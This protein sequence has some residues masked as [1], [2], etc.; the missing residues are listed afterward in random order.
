MS[1]LCAIT[2]VDK[3]INFKDTDVGISTRGN[4]LISTLQDRYFSI[5]REKVKSDLV[6]RQTESRDAAR[7]GNENLAE[8]QQ[9]VA[10]AS[11]EEINSRAE[12]YAKVMT[13]RP[14][15]KDIITLIKF[16]NDD[17][18][19]LIEELRAEVNS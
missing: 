13:K 16:K 14:S 5:V 4:K 18:I 7:V 15:R 2:G 9:A 11:D 1:D 8:G 17:I 12:M 6:K 10:L 19:K 3:I